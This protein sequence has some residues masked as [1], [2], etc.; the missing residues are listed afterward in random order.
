MPLQSRSD[1]AGVRS[2]LCKHNQNE[3]ELQLKLHLCDGLNAADAEIVT[4][5]TQAPK[6]SLPIRIGLR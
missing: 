1:F 5:K 3:E 6:G 4:N 2:S